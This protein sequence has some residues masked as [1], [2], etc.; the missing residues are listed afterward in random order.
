LF[1]IISS[2]SQS[3]HETTGF[4]NGLLNRFGS[5]STVF[6]IAAFCFLES[7]MSERLRRVGETYGVALAFPLGVK[8]EVCSDFHRTCSVNH[9]ILGRKNPDMG[10]L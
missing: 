3:L 10:P 6:G 2:E 7:C 8:N 4:F 9:F 1:F 5:K